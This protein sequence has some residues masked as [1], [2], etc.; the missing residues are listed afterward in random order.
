MMR[1]STILPSSVP[2][3]ISPDSSFDEQDEI[4]AT[5]MKN[6]RNRRPL[7]KQ[8]VFS[9]F[10]EDGN[11]VEV[12]LLHNKKESQESKYAEAIDDDDSALVET[13]ARLLYT[14]KQ[15]EVA[16]AAQASLAR[17]HSKQ[18]ELT[19]K[20]N[21][22]AMQ[23][24][25]E[26]A[27]KAESERLEAQ[28]KLENA[29]NIAMMLKSSLAE[30]SEKRRET[31]IKLAH[32]QHEIQKKE[33][34]LNATR[35]TEHRLTTEAKALVSTLQL[36]IHDGDSLYSLLKKAYESDVMKKHA[37]KNFH[38]ASSVLLKE[39]IGLLELL[40]S[41]VEEHNITMSKK[42]NEITG[43]FQV[44]SSTVTNLLETIKNQIQV[45][46]DTMRDQV[47]GEGGLTSIVS[48]ISSKIR[49]QM[50]KTET[51]FKEGET[52]LSSTCSVAC[53]RLHDASKQLAALE[54]SH[55]KLQDKSLLSLEQAV[56]ELKRKLNNVM[57][58]TE[59]AI[60]DAETV[61][62]S[63]HAEQEELLSRWKADALESSVKISSK[64]EE[65]SD[66]L[67]S[68]MT[69][70]LSEMD[71]HTDA[72]KILQEQQNFLVEGGQAHLSRVSK[73]ESLIFTNVILLEKAY[74]KQCE[75]RS[76]SIQ[77][78]MTQVQDI[79]NAE[80][81]RL[82]ELTEE[83]FNTF[84]TNSFE[85][86][87]ANT[88]IANSAKDILSKVGD[89]NVS[90]SQ[91]IEALHKNDQSILKIA[92]ETNSCLENVMELSKLQQESTNGFSLKAKQGLDQLANLDRLAIDKLRSISADGKEGIS[93]LEETLHPEASSAM[94][95]LWMSGDCIAKFTTD[96][97]VSPTIDS[98]DKLMQ[99]RK[100]ILEQVEFGKQELST[101][102]EEQ[103]N[104]ISVMSKEHHSTGV[105]GVEKMLLL[106]SEY[107]T[108]IAK[109]NYSK[110]QS[111][112]KEIV[113]SI[114]TFSGEHTKLLSSVI[115]K[116]KDVGNKMVKFTTTDLKM[117][118]E[119]SPIPNKK[120]F[121]FSHNLTQTPP[122]DI[123]LGHM[124]SSVHQPLSNSIV[125][126]D[127]VVV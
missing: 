23:E 74:K 71:H 85:L 64:A 26:R 25:L 32:L 91:Q 126:R 76:A 93:Y 100:E 78:I 31:E 45:M 49:D 82:S 121:S 109:E 21:A 110:V 59:E 96:S 75:F 87:K 118:E 50:Q 5:M 9:V 105:S 39:S 84:K 122:D 28:S 41:A 125:M 55:S 119:I 92:Q 12:S 88:V 60:R 106:S 83:Q 44:S 111:L 36:S 98:M 99:P 120:H 86:K 10:I 73:Q 77:N 46:A 68:A 116:S 66:I 65:K 123:I 11:E 37:T 112:E 101:L 7:T 6:V 69:T 97:I 104:N 80:M 114:S 29:N 47:S 13:E 3:S 20:N 54:D 43:N 16:Q 42:A 67:K 53:A 18:Q 33:L 34:I 107:E 79:I 56:T 124:S 102:L 94:K 14:Q 2:P 113:N 19:A 52:L 30:E 117:K 40:S 95:Q 58:T 72:S 63:A 48:Q 108:K 35:E 8:P 15:L 103:S 38:V 62:S 27:Q 90:I 115:D 22:I 57:K 127:G 4:M 81:L 70:F 1:A 61:R 89:T 17:K 24:L 51:T